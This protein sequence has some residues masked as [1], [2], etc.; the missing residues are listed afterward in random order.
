MDV[1]LRADAFRPA[2]PTDP[3]AWLRL[4]DSTGSCGFS[5]GTSQFAVEAD[6]RIDGGGSPEVQQADVW[7]RLQ[8]SSRA[9]E[10]GS[11]A[12]VSR[13]HV[14]GGSGAGSVPRSGWRL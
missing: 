13:R 14:A 2:G 5:C 9:T 6:R 1:G 11:G 10:A 8:A 7:S 3:V 12:G 4:S